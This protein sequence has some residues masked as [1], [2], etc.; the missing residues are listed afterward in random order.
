M[1]EVVLRAKTRPRRSKMLPRWILN[2]H[3]ILTP[4]GGRFGSIWG[5][6][7]AP[8]LAHV[9]LNFESCFAL[10]FKTP[11]EAFFDPSWSRFGVQVG[12]PK[13]LKVCNHRRI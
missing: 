1:L 10:V 11:F 2:L 6:I 3:E 13:A 12:G 4:L 9:G 8:K 5:P 7:L